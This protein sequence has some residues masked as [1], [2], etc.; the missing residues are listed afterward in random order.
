MDGVLGLGMNFEIP[1][2]SDAWNRQ[3]SFD[4]L[5]RDSK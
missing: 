4:V 2:R 1:R 3:E 5:A